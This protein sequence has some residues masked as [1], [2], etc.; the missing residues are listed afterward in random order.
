MLVNPH[1]VVVIGAG[2]AGL[3]AASYLHRHGVPVRVFEAGK[4][5]AGLA[6]SERDDEGFTYDFGAHFIT[7][8]LA[9]AV[10]CSASC[11]MMPRY[12]ETVYFN[13]TNSSYPTGL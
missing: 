3:T 5:L 1:P 6:R 10:G 8:R 13:C 7:N 12:G 11:R 9:A 2:V 4:N